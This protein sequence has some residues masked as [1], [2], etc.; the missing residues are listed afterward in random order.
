MIRNIA[1]LIKD[2]G[3]TPFS[4]TDS[5]LSSGERAQA[6]I[7]DVLTRE[8]DALDGEQMRA[9]VDVLEQSTQA[10]EQAEAWVIARLDQA[11]R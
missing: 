2:A 4:P 10:A 8:W 3:I 1:D 6:L 5:T 9:I 7:L 11:R